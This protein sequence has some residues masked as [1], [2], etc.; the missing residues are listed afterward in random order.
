M[1]YLVTGVPGAGKTLYALNWVKAF[2][3]KDGRTVFYSGIAQLTLP[4]VNVDGGVELESGERVEGPQDW[5]K[6]PAKS[7][8]VID[9]CQRIFR[10]RGHGV[11]VPQCVA[12]LETHRHRGIDLVLI[13]QHPMLMDTN[14]RRLVGTHFHVVRAFGMHRATVHEF[15]STREQADKNRTDSVRHEFKYPRESFGWYKS[16][17]VHTHKRR[18]PARVFF[19][20]AIPFLVSVLGYVLYQKMIPYGSAEGAASRIQKKSQAES[21]TPV[22]G[23]RSGGSSAKLSRSE[24]IAER[25]PRVAGVPQSAPVYDD[26]VR[27]V[28]APYPA[29]CLAMKSRGCRCYTDQATVLDVPEHMCRDIVERGYFVDFEARANGSAA[30]GAATK[31]SPAA[32][33]AS[34]AVGQPVVIRVPA[35]RPGQNPL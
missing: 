25:S 13:T 15:P 19:L 29:A 28:R 11:A 8:M 9:E 34:P 7:I 16:A 3:E 5:H 22:V 2:A 27:P 18:I 12:E 35:D 14:V 10:P 32:P 20:L 4:W 23:G 24:W 21:T 30:A 1:I 26:V 31:S 17:E 6:L 33:A